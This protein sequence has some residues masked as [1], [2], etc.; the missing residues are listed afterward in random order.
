M[1]KIICVSTVQE[2]RSL[3]AFSMPEGS[4]TPPEEKILRGPLDYLL[5]VSGKQI[6]TELILAFNEW[7]RI[8]DEKVKI[9]SDVVELLHTA[10]LLID[11]IQDASKL[12]RG[13]PVA[14]AIFGVPQTIN[15]A[16]YAYYLAQERM[17]D[18]MDPQAFRI[19]TE[20]LLNLHRGQGMELY[21]R[22]LLVC[23]TEEE[24]IKIVSNKTGG[25]LRL[26]WGLM[27]TQS[28]VVVDCSS[29]VE[30]LGIIYQIRDDYLNLQ[31]GLYMQKKGF[32]EDLSEGKFS[33][34]VIHCIT[35]SADNNLLL[36]ILKQRVN[37]ESIKAYAIRYME[38]AG[39]FKHCLKKLDMLWSEAIDIVSQLELSLGGCQRLRSILHRL[40][41]EST[42]ESA[43]GGNCY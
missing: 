32:G 34:P 4:R 3:P 19:F 41:V 16:N 7:L 43:S 37:D 24:Y 2:N 28:H 31:S 26:A 12:R 13:L 11:D 42:P 33:L 18:L 30:K 39:S 6:R 25:L 40:K 21:Y 17:Q 27:Q 35:S 14:H 22:D 5:S 23:P 38:A 29:L 8:P 36:S 9:I 10:S 15:S 20:E 1:E